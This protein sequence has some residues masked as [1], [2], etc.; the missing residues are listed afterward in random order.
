VSVSNN[1]LLDHYTKVTNDNL[2]SIAHMKRPVTLQ[3]IQKAR[4]ESVEAGFLA[5]EQ[6]NLFQKQYPLANGPITR[7]NYKQFA[8]RLFFVS[9]EEREK[10]H[11]HTKNFIAIRTA[12]RNIF[13]LYRLTQDHP[14]T[15]P[16][17]T[18]FRALRISLIQQKLEADRISTS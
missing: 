16:E 2:L 8:N 9:P 1:L 17:N 10:H 11:L 5:L 4:R 14:L 3:T 12:Y 18:L 7:E 6:L 13:E 15:G